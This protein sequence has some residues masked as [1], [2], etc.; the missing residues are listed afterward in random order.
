LDGGYAIRFLGRNGEP[1]EGFTAQITLVERHSSKSGTYTLKTD[2]N[3]EIHLGKL[4]NF[5]QIRCDMRN[6]PGNGNC[7]SKTYEINRDS[8]IKA[9]P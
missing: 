5:C 7:P 1:Y 4:E 6:M 8:R 3:G 9:T 2:K